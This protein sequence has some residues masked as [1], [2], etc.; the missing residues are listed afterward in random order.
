MHAADL[1]SYGSTVNMQV[2]AIYDDVRV[3]LVEVDQLNLTV[4][5]VT[6]ALQA[7]AIQVANIASNVAAVASEHSGNFSDAL[8]RAWDVLSWEMST[9]VQSSLFLAQVQQNQ[10]AEITADYV[11]ITAMIASISTAINQTRQQHTDVVESLNQ[12]SSAAAQLARDVSTIENTIALASTSL[13]ETEERIVSSQGA[14]FM[15]RDDIGTISS[16]LGQEG[17]SGLGPA[18][19]LGSASGLGNLQ[20]LTV[21]EG[22]S[23]LSLA[24]GALAG[25]VSRCADVVAS[26]EQR[27]ADLEQL[28][29]S[30]QR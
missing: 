22:I 14:L 17:Q 5:S 26:A 2:Q 24:V 13:N 1:Q 20:P 6:A 28:A 11:N 15:A 30:I 10:A 12:A 19:G 9:D 21:L 4:I 7:Q 29:A 16:L 8:E 18:S 23:S 25:S 27:A 3:A